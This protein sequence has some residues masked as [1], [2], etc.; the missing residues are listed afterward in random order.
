MWCAI[1]RP[2]PEGRSPGPVPRLSLLSSHNN[3]RPCSECPRKFSLSLCVLTC[4]SL[5]F[6]FS[7]P[8]PPLPLCPRRS[9]KRTTLAIESWLRSP[10]RIAPAPR[11]RA[12]PVST[13]VL[14]LRTGECP[15]FWALP[16]AGVLQN[17]KY[18][19]RRTF[20]RSFPVPSP[21]DCPYFWPSPYRHVPQLQSR[22][23]LSLG[24]RL[25]LL[26]C[27]L[28]RTLRSQYKTVRHHVVFPPSPH[29]VSVAV[30][31]SCLLL[32]FWCW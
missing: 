15:C 12:V 9:L 31:R 2:Q 13:A 23:R 10:V 14:L 20:G 11:S 8:D 30:S 24:L 16:L 26:R 19:C 22:P 32:M 17:K 29:Q 28:T 18:R 6:F 27:H 7:A 25:S 3:H 21:G 4:C 1:P 5:A